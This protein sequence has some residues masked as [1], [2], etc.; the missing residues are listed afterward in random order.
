MTRPQGPA[1]AQRP[2]PPAGPMRFMAGGRPPEKA[3]NFKASMLR[4]LGMMKP[5]RGVVALLLGAGVASVVLSVLTPKILGRATDIIFTGLLGKQV[6]GQFPAG[7]SKAQVVAAL[8]SG[9]NGRLAD[10]INS[11]PIVPGVGI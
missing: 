10:L 4:L 6:G 5:E 9:G 2:A 3:L 1:P 11:L 7:T 8:R